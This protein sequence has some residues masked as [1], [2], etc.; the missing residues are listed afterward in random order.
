MDRP[1]RLKSEIRV[2]SIL[3]RAASAGVAAVVARK[4]DA[5]AGTIAIKIYLGREIGARLLMEARDGGDTA[6]WRDA[7]GAPQPETTVD[8]R[9]AKE[10]RFDR[11]LWVIEID[12]RNGR[13]FAD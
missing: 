7:F 11:D 1:P 6:Q 2:A 12:D 13:S 10:A 3:R 5:D 9:L 4:G 8:E